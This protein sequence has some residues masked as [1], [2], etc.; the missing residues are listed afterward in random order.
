MRAVR[1][2]WLRSGE[3]AGWLPPSAAGLAWRLP[4][5]RHVRSIWHLAGVVRHDMAGTNSDFIRSGYDD[6]ALFG[7]WRGW[8]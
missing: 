4:L 3:M 2:E 1:A 6:W 5:I 8:V 7:M